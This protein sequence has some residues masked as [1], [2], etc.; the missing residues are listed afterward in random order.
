M[1]DRQDASLSDGVFPQKL[2][3]LL[4]VADGKMQ[5]ARFNTRFL[6]CFRGERDLPAPGSRQSGA[7]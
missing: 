6:V 7:Q 2:V 4:V 3:E 1:W 5:M